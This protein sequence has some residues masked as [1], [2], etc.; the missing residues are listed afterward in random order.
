MPK[1]TQQYLTDRRE[2]ILRAA[3]ECFLRDGFHATSMQ[4]LF[5]EAG[6]SA[7]AVYRYFASKD[8]MI[9]AIA[10][11]NMRDVIAMTHAMATQESGTSVGEALADA[12][13]VVAARHARDRLGGLAVQVWA[14]ASRNPA[15]RKQFN[16][17]IGNTRDELAAVV[18]RH[19]ASG[20]LP[21]QVS[22]E[23]LAA[24]L[25]SVL[26]GYLLQLSLMGPK[27]VEGVADA[28][29]ALWP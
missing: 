19:Q 22:A 13:E 29:R 21:A 25:L 14:E 26:P 20:D 5:A 27:A 6:L 7:G 15:L 28:I 8:E 24:V 4:D 2:H 9:I 11:E 1:V 16:K 18:R 23:A 10:E 12:V 17:L 3:R